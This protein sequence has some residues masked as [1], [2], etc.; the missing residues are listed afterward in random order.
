MA[1]VIL[2]KLIFIHFF[3]FFTKKIY[4]F[5]WLF[6]FII[7]R[8]KARAIPC[9]HQPPTK[10]GNTVSVAQGGT[11]TP[12]ATKQ[13]FPPDRVFNIYIYIYIYAR[14]T[15]S[16]DYIIRSSSFLVQFMIF[17]KYVY[18]RSSMSLCAYSNRFLML[19]NHSWIMVS[20]AFHSCWRLFALDQIQL[21]AYCTVVKRRFSILCSDLNFS[22][23][24]CS[25]FGRFSSVLYFLYVTAPNH[26]RQRSYI[27]QQKDIICWSMGPLRWVMSKKESS[28]TKFVH[29]AI[30]L[31]LGHW[32]LGLLGISP[33]RCR[34][35][36]GSWTLWVCSWFISPSFD[37]HSPTGEWR[38]L[39]CGFVTPASC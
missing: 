26:S 22:F 36:M 1:S 19:R 14:S 30:W 4:G 10:G 25:L 17:L 6:F 15:K 28:W 34:S 3:L 13:L 27:I 23:G 5:K 35:A 29:V 2:G 24:I 32:I 7:Q 31:P 12:D 16:K 39:P 37:L 21:Y 38:R 9:P 33:G 20:R 8:V 11:A 18:F